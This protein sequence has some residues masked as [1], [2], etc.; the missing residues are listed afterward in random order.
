MEMT[1]LPDSLT[2]GL[3]IKSHSTFHTQ[4]STLL[5]VERPAHE[6]L[7]DG[8]D[9]CG[10]IH[11]RHRDLCRM[12]RVVARELERAA[13]LRCYGVDDSIITVVADIP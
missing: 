11:V 1:G 10:V 5:I 13:L 2:S 3:P 9:V 12:A 7:I 4:H 8:N 6:I